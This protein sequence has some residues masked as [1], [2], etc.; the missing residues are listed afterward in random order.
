VAGQQQ[1]AVKVGLF[2]FLL[3]VAGALLLFVVGGSSDL[4]EDRYTLNAAW[5]DV[6]GLKP[7]APVRLAGYD[8]GEVTR[9][10][11]SDDLGV[12]EMFVEMKVMTRYRK[13]VRADSV[14]RIDTVGVLGDK[15]VSL[16]MGDPSQAPIDDGGWIET[17]DPLDFVAYS[18][19]VTGILDSTSNIG[20]KVDLMLGDDTEA[21]KASL[22]RSF[23]H[24]E[25]LLAEVETGGGLLH[26]LL[27]DDELTRSVKRTVGNLESMSSDLRTTTHA[28]RHGDGIAHE[29]IYGDDGKKLAKELSQLAD[30]LTQLTRDLKNE[31]S[32]V[33]ALIYDPS[34][35]QVI[36]DLAVTASQLRETSEAINQGD[37]T[38]GML[39]RDPALYEDLRALLGG[40]QRNKLLRAYIR[41][42]VA[43]GEASNASP[44]EPAD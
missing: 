43:E 40:A 5:S 41:K 30:A 7:G 8:V 9:I 38:L 1:R 22:A 20:H 15:Y 11:F 16:T 25:K 44:W 21:A 26:A 10:Q 3:A 42:T 17:E 32:L 4:L 23:D 14:A 33:H 34:K 24:L 2:V 12:K 36:D 27:Y 13:R 28:L 18:K 6:S 39:A 19:K 29:L 31:D 35:A 37:G